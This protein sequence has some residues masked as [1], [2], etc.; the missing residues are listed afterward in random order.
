MRASGPDLC[1]L[2][3]LLA[4][5]LALYSSVC[6]LWWTYD[7]LFV[8]HLARTHS[9]REI[10]FSPEL[11]QGLPSRMF[12]PLLL[13]SFKVDAGLFG[14]HPGAFY[15]HHLV[16]LFGGTVV[17]YLALR[18]R[19]PPSSSG[20]M[21]AL[22]LL[23]LP[24]AAWSLRLSCRHY[25]EGFLLAGVSVL[26]FETATAS[27]RRSA[28]LSASSYFLSMLGKEIFVPLPVL[29]F[30]LAQGDFRSKLIRLRY[31]GLALVVYLV[32]RFGMLGAL[33]GG[34]GWTIRREELGRLALGLP[35]EA[36]LLLLPPSRALA[37]VLASAAGILVAAALWTYPRSRGPALVMTAVVLAPLLPVAK[38]LEP[39]FAA[40]LW[41]AV[42]V[43]AIVGASSLV[44]RP[45]F[46]QGS[47]TCGVAVLVVASVGSNRLDWARSMALFDRMSAEGR[48]FVTMRPGDLLRKPA[49]PAGAMEQTRWLRETLGFPAGAFWF[50]DDIYPCMNAIAGRVWEYRDANRSLVPLTPRQVD[51]LSSYC[52]SIRRD[53]PLSARFNQADNAIFWELGPYREGAYSLV[54]DAGAQAF[55]VRSRD[56]YQVSAGEFVTMVRYRSPEGWTTYSPP[57]TV[58]LRLGQPFVWHRP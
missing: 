24:V 45:R 50:A 11:W 40:L 18:R 39:R 3:G 22:F 46:G 51:D 49:I 29:L 58:D 26:A 13:L 42:C 35:V 5:G 43:L 10:L 55:P 23:G 25:L 38:A 27:E 12:T 17:L 57:L 30:F 48:G 8:L 28:I 33:V 9:W 16:I 20:L 32:W 19:L 6:R 54:F 34:Y 52:R 37:V 14:L 31:H 36:V 41:L 2:G 1:W 15:V 44:T 56:G 53:A 7:D 4:L 21:A 47:A